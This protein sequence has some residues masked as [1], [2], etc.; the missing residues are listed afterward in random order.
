MAI[1]APDLHCLTILRGFRARGEFFWVLWCLGL[2]SPQRA[3]RKMQEA[4]EAKST[5]ER[6]KWFASMA[7]R[8]Q[9][10]SWMK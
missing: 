7:A 10:P 3:L 4:A 1:V 5:C 9:F 6:L 2:V 8:R